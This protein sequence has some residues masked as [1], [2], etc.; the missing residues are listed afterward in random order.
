M[1]RK[2]VSYSTELFHGF[3][4]QISLHRLY[5]F[6]GDVIFKVS[7]VDPFKEKWRGVTSCFVSLYVVLISAVKI[8]VHR[9]YKC[10]LC[11]QNNGTEPCL[12]VCCA[13]N[14]R[15]SFTALIQINWRFIKQTCLSMLYIQKVHFI[16]LCKNKK[17][18]IWVLHMDAGGRSVCVFISSGNFSSAGPFGRT[19]GGLPFMSHGKGSRFETL[20]QNQFPL[21]PGAAF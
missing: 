13:V 1:V 19:D 15:M 5:R 18:L 8:P 20:L 3:V 11:F 7:I 9:R 2:H 21:T 14:V 12:A 4:W 16:P 10:D 6:K 17:R